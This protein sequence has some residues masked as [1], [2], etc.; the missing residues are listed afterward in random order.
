MRKG[1]ERFCPGDPVVGNEIPQ[2][3]A[4]LKA[5]AGPLRLKVPRL[6]SQGSYSL[7]ELCRMLYLRQ[8]A[9]SHHLKMLTEIQ[10]PAPAVRLDSPQIPPIRPLC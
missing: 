8:A 7:L 2:L 4:P 3:A 5:A 6:L 10:L 1:G 9:L